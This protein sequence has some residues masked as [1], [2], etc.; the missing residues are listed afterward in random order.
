MLGH[1]PAAPC[2]ETSHIDEDQG[3]PRYLAGSYALNLAK[4]RCPDSLERVA[5]MKGDAMN[6]RRQVST[7]RYAPA[8]WRRVLLFAGALLAGAGSAWLVFGEST[9]PRAETVVVSMSPWCDCC[10]AWVDYMK[11]AGFPVAVIKTDELEMVK[12]R[13]GVPDDLYSCHTAEI[14]GYAVEGHVPLPAIDRLL[15][16]RPAIDGIALAGMP[17]GSPGMGGQPWPSYP[18]EAFSENRLD[19]RF[20]DAPLR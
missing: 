19:S 13:A 2:P 3:C 6:K 16:E 5:P 9:P 20:M 15:A 12:Q 17:A 4:R 14:A 10:G 11:Q 18:V 7:P 8:I 1:Y